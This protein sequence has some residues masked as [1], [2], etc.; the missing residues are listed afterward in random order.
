MVLDTHAASWSTTNSKPS[1]LISL[2]GFLSAAAPDMAAGRG[3]CAG[4]CERRRRR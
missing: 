4:A 3:K 2:T 1:A